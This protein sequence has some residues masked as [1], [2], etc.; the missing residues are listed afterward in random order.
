MDATEETWA[1][2]EKDNDIGASFAFFSTFVIWNSFMLTRLF[3]GM[4]C[5]FFS[6]SSGSVLMT[7]EQRNWQ[8]MSM[9]LVESLKHEISRPKGKHALRA[10]LFI[11]NKWVRRF[12][13]LTI[14][15]SVVSMVGQQS[16]LQM[17]PTGLA[18]EYL[19]IVDEYILVVYT[20]E[21]LISIVAFGFMA[22]V[23]EYQTDYLVLAT[24]WITVGHTILRSHMDFHWLHWVQSIQFFRGL[25][26][27]TVFTQIHAMKKIYFLLRVALP[28]VL[29][30]IGVMSVVFF[31][32]GCCAQHLC[33]D[34]PRGDVITDLD[35]FDTVLSSV[36]LLFQICTGQSLMGVTTECRAVAGPAAVPFF[37]AF[38][39][40]TNML[41]VNLFIALLLDNFDLMGSEDMAVS[42]MDIELFKRTWQECGLDLH[43]TVN[44][45][46]L[47]S[48]VTQDGMGTF[49]M[50]PKAD[51]HYFNRVLFELGYTHTDARAAKKEIAFFPL[52]LALC[53]VRFSSSCLS[54]ADEVDKSQKL[55]QQHEDHAARILQV[56]ARAW[57]AW[58]NPPRW[59]R[60]EKVDRKEM[61]RLKTLASLK[62]DIEGDDHEDEELDERD[63]TKI[64]WDCAVRIASVWCMNSL[65]KTDRITPEHVVAEA[66]G[67]LQELVDKGAAP[68]PAS[69]ESSRVREQST[70]L[71]TAN[72]QHPMRKM[73][74]KATLVTVTVADVSSGFGKRTRRMRW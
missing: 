63:A 60:Y 43:G 49:S 21:A 39:V 29:N 45:A 34:L 3:T 8:F 53:H 59:V 7:A 47:Q 31:V 10:F 13:N 22:Y 62:A 5:D 17:D 38:F 27:V 57:L 18:K 28:Q 50:M 26:L 19:L 64:T 9:F 65:I 6:Q 4:L 23:R 14:I 56:Q 2:P 48:F 16:L 41:L 61:T 55:V 24:L 72:S 30:L 36:M 73:A 67:R 42:D 35:N 74:R 71:A 51:R 68:R 46:E 11:H 20:L 12:L 37:I 40:A 52:I 33:G 32:L 15:V 70:S 44:I 69:L 25:R 58:R 54:I 1:A 66:F